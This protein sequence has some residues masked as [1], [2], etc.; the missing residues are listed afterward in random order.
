LLCL[1]DVRLYQGKSNEAL[2]IVNEICAIFPD[3]LEAH[4][5]AR[6]LSEGEVKSLMHEQ[7]AI[8]NEWG[9]TLSRILIEGEDL[10]TDE[11]KRLIRWAYRSSI[12]QA[13]QAALGVSISKVPQLEGLANEILVD[14]FVSGD[15]KKPILRRKILAGKDKKIKLVT[16]NALKTIDVNPPASPQNLRVAYCEV[17]TYLAIEDLFFEKNFAIAVDKLSAAMGSS[18]EAA[19]LSKHL[20]AAVLY[21]ISTAIVDQADACQRFGCTSEEFLHAREILRVSDG[22]KPINEGFMP[23]GR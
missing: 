12:N 15:V 17:L 8:S 14:P 23:K 22:D 20:V 13:L 2:K 11:A 19:S 16:K 10:T 18:D 3:D 21:D 5:L 4:E 7:L 1:G 9:D 6:R